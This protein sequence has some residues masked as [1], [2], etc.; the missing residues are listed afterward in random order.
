MK[1][2]LLSDLHTEF[3]YGRPL[4]MLRGLVFEPNLD[5]LLLPGDIVVPTKAQNAIEV[6]EVF[7]F[8]AGK[9]RHV[10]YTTGN[11]EYYHGAKDAVEETL[12]LCM[13]ENFHY[14]ENEEITLDGVHFYGGCMWFNNADGMDPF[15]KQDINDFHLIKDLSYWVY[16]RN[17]EFT[18]KAWK[19]IRP[20]TVVLTH[21]LC[22]PESTPREYKTSTMNRFFLCDQTKLIL[23]KEPRLWV[24]GH[25]HSYARYQVGNKTEVVCNPYG[26]PQERK[27]FPKYS[28][29]LLEI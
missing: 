17:N 21:H 1:A 18:E 27:F 10:I 20:E 7:E 12:K 15:Y 26:Y 11:H 9:A 16:Q 4:D 13:P 6:R 25:T 28:P 29:V 14:L 5:F 22:T 3:Y 23:E 2:Q 8:L 24:H 19:L